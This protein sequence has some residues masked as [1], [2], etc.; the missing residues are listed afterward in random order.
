MIRIRRGDWHPLLPPRVR[1]WVV[2]VV[3][4]VPLVWGADYL[5]GT[6]TS[7]SLSVVEKAL[8]IQWWG[9]ACL[10][11]GALQLVGFVGRWIWVAITGA[12]ASGSLLATLATGE[13]VGIVHAPGWDGFRGPALLALVAYASFGIAIGYAQ[14]AAA[15]AEAVK[16]K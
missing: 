12:W 3:P 10:L 9:I 7:E 15:M 16:G 5:H 11:V 6:D 4:G 1:A 13:F 8:P 14:Q 2:G